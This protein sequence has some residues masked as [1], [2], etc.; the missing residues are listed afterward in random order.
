MSGAAVACQNKGLEDMAQG[1]GNRLAPNLS[2]FTKS[3]TKDLGSKSQEQ[4]GM[5]V[6]GSPGKEDVEV[7]AARTPGSPIVPTGCTCWAVHS[8]RGNF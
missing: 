8:C 7:E 4:V 5:L 6:S 1:R 3:T 2:A